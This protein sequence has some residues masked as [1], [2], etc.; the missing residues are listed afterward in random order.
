MNSLELFSGA[1]GLAKG[2]ELAGFKHSVLV[3]S[4]KHAYASLCE[5]F[6]AEKVF[7]G[8]VRDFNLERL[9]NIDLVAG[10]PPCQPFS[11][12]GKHQADRDKRD[13]FPAAIHA[14][15]KLKS[16]SLNGNWHLVRTN[17]I[18]RHKATSLD[19]SI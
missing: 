1:G 5:N 11:L 8:N 10:G 15:E 16:A 9:D 14:I 6:D 13:M 18:E 7:F 3:E 19:R 17:S 4:N 2:L 12:G